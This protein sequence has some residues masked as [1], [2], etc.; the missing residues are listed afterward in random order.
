VAWEQPA[1]PEGSTV[2]HLAA[3]ASGLNFGDRRVMAQPGTRRIYS[4]AGF[5]VLAETVAAATGMPF[6]TYLDEAVCR[7]LV[8]SGTALHG[9]AGHGASS[10]CAD[11]TAFAAE[12]LSPTLVARETLD[13]AATVAFPG[14]DGVLPGYGR[15][16]PNDWG[17]GFE[18][19][20]AKHPHWTGQR[21]SA[22]TFG[23]FGQSGTFCWVDPRAGAAAVALT[24]RDFGDWAKRAW[25]AF[26]DAVLAEVRPGS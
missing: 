4:S 6:A 1:G 15:Q 8:M 21:S 20:D 5:E 23:H 19:A 9:S 12:L 18:L 11:M 13:E 14:L 22:E 7:P 17:L 16:S 2:R 25:P 24:D 10:T 3:H 26:T